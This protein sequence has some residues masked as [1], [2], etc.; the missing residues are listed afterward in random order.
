[1]GLIWSLTLKMENFLE[2]EQT[3]SLKQSQLKEFFSG[4]VNLV[5]LKLI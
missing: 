3:E 1:M 2:T 5:Y 4:S